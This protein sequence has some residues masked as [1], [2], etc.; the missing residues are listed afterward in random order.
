MLKKMPMPKG[1]WESMDSKYRLE[2][3]E[4]LVKDKF[5]TCQFVKKN[6]DVRVIN[7]RLGV[8]KHL[9]NP[10]YV[11]KNQTDY[12][13]AYDLQIKQYRNI[14]LNKLQWLRLNNIQLDIIQEERQFKNK[15]KPLFEISTLIED[16]L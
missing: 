12:I 15:V 5:F 6:G 14:S 7:C 9:K 8:K 10:D 16:K 2:F 13:V 3:V 11:R 1:F 4:N